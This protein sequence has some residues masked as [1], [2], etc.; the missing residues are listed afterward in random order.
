MITVNVIPSVSV[1]LWAW[2]VLEQQGGGGS[3]SK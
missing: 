3:D 1:V 2:A